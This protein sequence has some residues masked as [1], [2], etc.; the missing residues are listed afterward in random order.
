MLLSHDRRYVVK[1]ITATEK[2]TLV[3]LLE[4]YPQA[5]PR[6][7]SGHNRTFFEPPV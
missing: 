5:A 2:R 1:Q 3:G 6:G 7:V 4:D